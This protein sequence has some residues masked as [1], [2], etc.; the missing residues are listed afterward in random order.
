MEI[1]ITVGGKTYRASYVVKPGGCARDNVV[2]NC[3]GVVSVAEVT[4]GSDPEK[5]AR[6]LLRGMVANR[7]LPP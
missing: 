5:V 3:D 7:D 6:D 4:P 1:E 2:V